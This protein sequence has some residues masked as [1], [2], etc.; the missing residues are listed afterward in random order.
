MKNDI[1]ADMHAA[2]LTVVRQPG[3]PISQH[4]RDCLK[5][6]R[7]RCKALSITMEAVRGMFPATDYPAIKR[8]LSGA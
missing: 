3:E 1:P 7:S 8:R 6:L 4:Q 2:A 5:Y